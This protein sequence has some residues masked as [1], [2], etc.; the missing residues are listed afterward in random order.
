MM[1]IFKE[2]GLSFFN[3]NVKIVGGVSAVPN[4][5]PSTAFIQL[6]YKREELDPKTNMTI[7]VEYVG[8][9]LGSLIDKQTVL[10]TSNCFPSGRR[11]IS[12]N[13]NST[14]YEAIPNK[15]YPTYESMVIVYLGKFCIIMLEF[16]FI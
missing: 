15:Y 16:T 7:A 3:P 1:F 11:L 2:C 6:S 9:C 10:T 5:W 4:S 14:I 8:K 13:G 12:K